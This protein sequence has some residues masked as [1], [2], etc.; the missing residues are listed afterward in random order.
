MDSRAHKAVVKRLLAVVL[1]A[2]LCFILGRASASV[3]LDPAEL[4]PEDY[5]TYDP[6]SLSWVQ[7]GILERISELQDELAV[8]REIQREKMTG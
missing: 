8:V 3:G 2:V 7:E 6:A 1:L 5:T 4:P